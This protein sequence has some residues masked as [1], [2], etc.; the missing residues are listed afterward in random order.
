M[1]AKA[2]PG[3][4]ACEFLQAGSPS[5]WSSLAEGTGTACAGGSG[6]IGR[7]RPRASGRCWRA[8][9][10]GF[11]DHQDI[12]S[13]KSGRMTPHYSAS[14]PGNLVAAINRIANLHG[15]HA[16]TAPRFVA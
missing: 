6:A 4:L 5:G 2:T 15:I 13:H 14:E 1:G 10:V 11:E 7:A 16:L 9:G 8:A 12:L 3:V